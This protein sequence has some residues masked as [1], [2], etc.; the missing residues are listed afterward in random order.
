MVELQLCMG[1][2]DPNEA[3]IRYHFHFLLYKRHQHFRPRQLFIH[4]QINEKLI[5]INLINNLEKISI[6]LHPICCVAF[7]RRKQK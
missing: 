7:K 5:Q 4:F 3:H 1:C 6:Q 2:V